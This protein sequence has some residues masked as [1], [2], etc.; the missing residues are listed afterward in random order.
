MY[1]H[2]VWSLMWRNLMWLQY[3]SSTAFACVEKLWPSI[4]SKQYTCSPKK[5]VGTS[6]SK[7]FPTFL[8]CKRKASFGC[9][10][11]KR[12]SKLMFWFLE[13]VHHD[14]IF[15]FQI[16]HPQALLDLQSS[17]F[18]NNCF[19]TSD[20]KLQSYL[21]NFSYKNRAFPKYYGVYI[22]LF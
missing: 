5:K 20:E 14:I 2:Q 15:P 1:R 9:T 11:F 8:Q 18:E 4:Q 6:K 10:N 13:L 7:F 21:Q 16:L 3:V 19:T 17:C 22:K 12:F